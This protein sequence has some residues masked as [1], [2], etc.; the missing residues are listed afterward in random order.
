MLRI[1]IQF[2][3]EQHMTYIHLQ[4]DALPAL[5][6]VFECNTHNTFRDQKNINDAKKIG[7]SG[8]KKT[9]P[10]RVFTRKK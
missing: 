4:I 1:S 2:K 5:L 6:S 3:Y 10:S 8:R 7:L 9:A